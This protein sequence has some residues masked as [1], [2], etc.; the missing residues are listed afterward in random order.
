MQED[1]ERLI[2]KISRITQILAELKNSQ[3]WQFIVEDFSE[4]KQ[5]IDDSWAFI[6]STE[7]EKLSELRVS[8][9]AIMQVIN[10]IEN[11]EHDLKISQESLNRFDSPSS[12]SNYGDQNS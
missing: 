12:D 11:Y 9:M 4:T 5:R 8:K 3:A 10:L 1:K 2:K 6:P 7:P